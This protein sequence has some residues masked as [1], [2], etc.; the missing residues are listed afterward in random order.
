MYPVHLFPLAMSWF[1]SSES[2]ACSCS[3]LWTQGGSDWLSGLILMTQEAEAADELVH[4]HW[5]EGVADA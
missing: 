1:A 2:I 4:Q 3:S 5:T